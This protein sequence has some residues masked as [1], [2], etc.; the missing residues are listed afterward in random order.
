MPRLP[1]WVPL[2]SASGQKP[3]GRQL[4]TKVCG[5][6]SA[7]FHNLC[8]DHFNQQWYLANGLSTHHHFNTKL[9]LIT[10]RGST[11][12]QHLNGFKFTLVN[13]SYS[14][15]CGCC[16][17]RRMPF[18]NFGR[19]CTC[20]LVPRPKTMIIGL[21]TRLVHTSKIASWPCALL[22][23]SL[24]VIVGKVY[25]HRIGKALHSVANL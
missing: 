13:K 10:V 16:P 7:I 25:E 21:G 12:T 14:K 24:P 1:L 15:H 19:M 5:S 3:H 20:S 23:Q 6:E 4:N 17:L 2:W 8:S 18:S 9:M 22:A 11:T